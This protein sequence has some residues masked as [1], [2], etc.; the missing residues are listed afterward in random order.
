MIVAAYT[1]GSLLPRIF[2]GN[3]VDRWLRQGVYLIGIA[4]IAVHSPLVAVTVLLPVIIGR[5]F[6]QGVGFSG[7]STSASEAGSAGS[8]T[9]GPPGARD[10]SRKAALAHRGKSV[11]SVE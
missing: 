10:S 6:L 8:A 5:R 7:S 11:R 4:I 3:L 1:L 2:W 9:S